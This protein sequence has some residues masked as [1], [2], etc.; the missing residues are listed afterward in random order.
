MSL[1]EL[2]KITANIVLL[3]AADTSMGLTSAELAPIFKDS[4]LQ[5]QAIQVPGQPTQQIQIMSL[6]EQVLVAIG[7]SS[8][9]FEDKSAD[10]PPKGRLAEIV[11]AFAGLLATKGLSTFRAYGFN[12]EIAFDAPGDHPAARL[13]L[14]RF[15]QADK[16]KERGKIEPVG[17]GL[18]LYFNTGDAK[19]DLRIEP[20]ENKPNSQRLF[21]KVNY[22]YELPDGA[23]PSSDLMKS[24]FKGKW[25]IFTEQL[26]RLLAS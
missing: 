8:L 9:N 24:D 2:E 10:T 14:D 19:C 11:N 1:R 12:F 17:A 21:A 20:R 23:L 5:V 6:R 13:L 7:A 3:P 26:E 22:H 25:G 4:A 18:R 15:V 16:L